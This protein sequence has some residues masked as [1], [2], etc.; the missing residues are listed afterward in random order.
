MEPG[1]EWAEGDTVQRDGVSR[2]VVK[3]KP[4]DTYLE[5]GR[6]TRVQRQGDGGKVAAVLKESEGRS[7]MFM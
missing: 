6:D 2:V 3:V 4:Q 7:G 5:E 1:W